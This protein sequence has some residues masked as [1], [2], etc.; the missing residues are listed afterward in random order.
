MQQKNGNCFN[1]LYYMCEI[2]CSVPC[3]LDALSATYLCCTHMKILAQG[4]RTVNQISNDKTNNRSLSQDL[5][6]FNADNQ[7]S[8]KANNNHSFVQDIETDKHCIY[9]ENTFIDEE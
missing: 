4:R 6:I 2:A 7:D 1:V 9:I 5:E 3:E 8:I